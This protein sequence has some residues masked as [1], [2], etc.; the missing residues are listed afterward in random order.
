M[1]SLTLQ[2]LDKAFENARQKATVLAK[3]AGQTL[4]AAYEIVEHGAQRPPMPLARSE[5]MAMTAEADKS[6]ATVS[7]GLIRIQAHLSVTFTVDP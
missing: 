4:G 1:S 6:S 5:L 3:S 2:A 7:S